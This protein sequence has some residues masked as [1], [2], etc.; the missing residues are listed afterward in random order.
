M[1]ICCVVVAN[2]A[3]AR[4]FRLETVESPELESG[5]RLLEQKDLVNPESRVTA[6]A[7]FADSGTTSWRSAQGAPGHGYS[8]HRAEH[9]DEYSRRFAGEI[10]KE[11]I[12]VVKERRAGRVVLVAPARM[13]G[14]LRKEMDPSMYSGIEVETVVND[15]TKLSPKDI[16]RHLANKGILPERKPPTGGA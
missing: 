8:D 12:L 2:E 11:A 1:S 10:L 5:P 4:L 9:R 7:M 13:V 16:H 6:G 3:R 14:F 15:M